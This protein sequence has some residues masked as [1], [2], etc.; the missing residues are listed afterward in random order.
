L[1]VVLLVL[2]LL[3]WLLLL[4]VVLVLL[5]LFV[6]VGGV[7]VVVVVVVVVVGGGGGGG[8]VAVAAEVAGVACLL[9]LV[10]CLA[11]RLACPGGQRAAPYPPDALTGW[12]RQA[13]NCS[14]PPAAAGLKPRRRA[15]GR[16]FRSRFM[17]PIMAG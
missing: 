4:L 5:L 9:R 3:W 2:L 1:V 16:I 11:V 12:A 13:P 10:R 7:G 17:C 6:V 8:V 14:S 15:P